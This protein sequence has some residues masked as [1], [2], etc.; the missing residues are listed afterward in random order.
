MSIETLSTFEA[1]DTTI[2]YVL[3]PDS[4]AVGLQLIPTAMLDRVVQPRAFYDVPAMNVATAG[5]PAHHVNM[6]VHLHCRG[7]PAP[8]GISLGTMH[9]TPATAS[10]R[11]DNQDV[12][13]DERGLRVETRLKSGWGFSCQH[14]LS[15]QPGEQALELETR[16]INEGDKPITLEDISSFSLGGITPFHPED[17]PSRLVLHRFRSGW[18]A[19]GRL[20]SNLLEELNMERSYPGF[21]MRRERFGQLGTKATKCWFPLAA[22][23]D[24]GAGVVW[25]GQLAW[26]GSWQMEI[27]RRDDWVALSGGLADRE[28]GHW[29]KVIQ[30][31]ETFSGPQAV[32]ACVQGDLDALCQRLT[33]VQHHAAATA[34]GVEV[35]LPIIYNDW[36]TNWGQ[37]SHESIVA[38]AERLQGTPTKYLVIDAGWYGVGEWMQKTGDWLPSQELFPRGLAATAQAIRDR[39]LIPGIWFEWEVCG[40]LSEAYAMTDHQVKL[41]G[42]TFTAGDR[43]LWDMTDPF[44]ID[45]LTERVI[46]LLDQCGFGYLKVDYNSSLGFGCDGAESP[47]E[48]IRQQVAGI[49]RF[50]KRIREH[51]PDL[52]IENCSSGGQRLEPSL[53]ALCS[54]GSFSDAFETLDVPIIAANLHRLILPHQSQVWAVLRKTDDP[55]RIVYT[56]AA[57]FLGR[58]CISGDITDLTDEQWSLVLAAQ[59]LYRQVWP[60]IKHG[61]SS[62]FGPELY[63]YL[64]PAGWQGVIRVAD[65]GRTALAVLHRFSDSDGKQVA[66]PLPA[67]GNWRIEGLYVASPDQAEIQDDHLHVSFE[68][69]F[70]GGVVY[71]QKY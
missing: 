63:S 36:P 60:V 14:I 5:W 26:A 8:D 7:L 28:F 57:A 4:Q 29:F 22:V 55:Q 24:I 15:W 32:V 33:H 51:L 27:Y 64:Q 18:S 35:D 25:G 3:D 65:D 59:S 50:F 10:L 67:N 44:V 13:Q 1:G 23:E 40:P 37:P 41:D 6:L 42:V 58:M 69:E 20:E 34:P 56:M 45:Y 19:E 46:G 39:G 66:L 71:L 43:H 68:Q 30:P 54:M 52:V 12:Q 49:Y 62:R 61:V 16:F 9:D 53:Q 11:Y 31:G 48:G 2:R 21:A 70:S 17:A 47:G 38:I